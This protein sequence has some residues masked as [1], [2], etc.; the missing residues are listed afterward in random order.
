MDLQ[1]VKVYA[2]DKKGRVVPTYQGEVTFDVSGEAKL[3]AVDNGDHL[4]DRIFC[5][6]N[7]IALHNGFAMAVLRSNRQSGGVKVTASCQGVK[8]AEK[9]MITLASFRTEETKK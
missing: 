7:S 4:T 2:V 8:R 5:Q 1:Y 9:K 6:G 3:I